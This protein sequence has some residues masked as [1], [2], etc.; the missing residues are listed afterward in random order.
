V[1]DIITF[2]FLVFEPFAVVSEQRGGFDLRGER[3]FG[4]A[5]AWKID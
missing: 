4:A 5:T 1:L 2:L 3:R